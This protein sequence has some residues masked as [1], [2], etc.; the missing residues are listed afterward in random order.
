MGR[1]NP[2]SILCDLCLTMITISSGGI[3]SIIQ[4]EILKSLENIIGL[5]IP[6]TSFFDLI[7]GTR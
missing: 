7:I 2:D 5:E 1:R 3:R 6:I 4:L